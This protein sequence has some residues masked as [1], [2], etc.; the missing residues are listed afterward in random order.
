M[1]VPLFKK[2]PVGRLGSRVVGWLGSVVWVSGSFPR[3][4]GELSEGEMSYT[5]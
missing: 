5:R 4:G 1:L 2:F 3:W